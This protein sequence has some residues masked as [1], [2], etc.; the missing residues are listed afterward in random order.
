MLGY[1]Q[2]FF[3]VLTNI[4]ID[5]RDLAMGLIKIIY[6]TKLFNNLQYMKAPK[7]LCEAIQLTLNTT[8][9]TKT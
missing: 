2:T 5:Q 3:F 1:L 9:I 7:H 4:G 6:Y 8:R